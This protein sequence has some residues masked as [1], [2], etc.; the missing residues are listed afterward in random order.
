MD[1]IERIKDIEKKISMLE[2]DISD[3]HGAI[4]MLE[5]EIAE[6]KNEIEKL[7]KGLKRCFKCNSYVEQKK[8]INWNKKKYFCNET[9]ESRYQRKV[10]S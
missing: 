8:S 6:S 5:G 10:Y 1:K 7:S 9:C 2:D 4:D 3:Y